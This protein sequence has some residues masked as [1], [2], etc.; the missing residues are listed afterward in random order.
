MIT[1]YLLDCLFN[2]KTTMRRALFA[3]VIALPFVF[4]LSA[5]AQNSRKSVAVEEQKDYL[6]T[7][8]IKDLPDETIFYLIRA[9]AEGRADTVTRIKSRNGTFF[10]KGTME[11]VPEMY[12]LKMD[13]SVVKITPKTNSWIRILLNDTPVSINGSLKDWPN[14]SLLGS[15][16][17][18]EYDNILAA[19]DTVI[20]E[21]SMKM[22]AARKEVPRDSVK[23]SLLAKELREKTSNIL[24]SFPNAYATPLLAINMYR[25]DASPT[26]SEEI[27]D[28]LSPLVKNSFYGIK[29]EKQVDLLRISEKIAEGNI[30][31]AFSFISP[32]GKNLNILE[33]AAKSKLTLIDFW[34]SWCKPCR[35]EIPNLLKVYNAFHKKGF[36]IIGISSDA[37]KSAWEK[38]MAED[39]TPWV[40]GLEEVPGRIGK[41]IFQLQSIPAFALIDANGRLL[42]FQRGMSAVRSF[43]PNIQGEK[44]YQT[45]ERVLERIDK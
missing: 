32:S 37:K 31:P 36:N 44:L 19:L 16:L 28:C 14:I 9:N 13:T 33:E 21:N 22:A 35:A 11:A 34:A 2:I 25:M 10:M 40:H 30:I 17:T 45:I 39:N 1:N 5:N 38:A 7:G 15:N 24:K 27:Y 41:E 26:T 8:N 43:G 12:F 23:I 20:K 42:A 4:T 29:L 6:I 18:V 3:L